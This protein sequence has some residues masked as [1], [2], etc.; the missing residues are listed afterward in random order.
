MSTIQT[1]ENLFMNEPQERPESEAASEK[2]YSIDG[3]VFDC[4]TPGEVLE[5][6]VNSGEFEAGRIYF[7]ANRRLIKPGDVFD[8][9]DLLDDCDAKLCDLM[10]GEDA[11][12]PFCVVGRAKDELRQLVEDWI[13]RHTNITSHWLVS[14]EVREIAVTAEDVA[15]HS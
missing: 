15:E 2:C 3:E 6:L 10:S 5:L 1:Q 7:E 11:G 4:D 13:V 8:V 14:G 9:N 12:D